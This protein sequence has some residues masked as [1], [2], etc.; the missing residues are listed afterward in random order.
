MS[1]VAVVGLAVRAPSAPTPR[2]LWARLVSGAD[3]LTR[4]GTAAETLS[5]IDRRLLSHGRHVP[6]GGVL[7]GVADIDTEFFELSPLDAALTDPQ[8]RVFLEVSREALDDAASPAA[9]DETT[10]VFAGCGMS[11]YLQHYLLSDPDLVERVGAYPLMLGNDKDFLATR[12]SYKLGLGGPSVGVQTACSTSLVAVHLAVAALLAGECDTAVAGGVTIRLPQKRGYLYQPDGV[13]SADG[14][15]RPFDSDATGFVPS[16]GAVAIVL[17]RLEDAIEDGDPI[18]AVLLATAVN[19]DGADRAGFTAPGVAGQVRVLSEALALS[20]LEPDDV[21]HV[22]THGTGTA[23]GDVVEFEALRKVYGSGTSPCYLGAGKAVIG[24]TDTAAGGLGLVK[25][26]LALQYRLI[27]PI[28]NFI[29]PNPRLDLEATRFRVAT[30]A[31]EW[32][33]AAPRR[34]AVTSLGLGGTNAHVLVEEAPQHR[35]RPRPGVVL[36]VSAH[37]VAATRARADQLQSLLR[38]DPGRAGGLARAL[39]RQRYRPVRAAVEGPGSGRISSTPAE[40]VGDP[41]RVALAFPGGGSQHAGMA[42]ALAAAE[43]DFAAAL[44]Q[45]ID[46]VEPLTGPG[47]RELLLRPSEDTAEALRRP[48]IGLPALFCVQLGL[49][50][51]LATRG[52]RPSAVIG[53]SSG[54][55]VAAC[56]AGVLAPH[57]AAEL[58]VT[59]ARMFES[60]GG[61]AMVGLLLT[62]E[63]TQPYLAV[64]PDL[65]IAAVNG[66][67]ETVVG[68]PTASVAA[69]EAHLTRLGLPSSRIRVDVAAHTTQVAHV[70]E[71]LQEA[72]ASIPLRSP[73][74]P[75]VSHVTG[76]WVGAGTVTPAY[77]AAHLRQTVRFGDA[78]RTLLEPGTLVLDVG[79]GQVLRASIER[80]GLPER[81]RVV[82]ALPHPRHDVLPA[83]QLRR[84]IVDLWAGGAEIDLSRWLPVEDVPVEPLP[85]YPFQ[86]RRCWVDPP[87]PSDARS[88]RYR[89]DRPVVEEVPDEP[90]RSEA[91]TSDEGWRAWAY[92]ADGSVFS[93]KTGSGLRH[94][95]VATIEV[96]AVEQLTSS[97]VAAPSCEGVLVVAGGDP[98][99]AYH[100]V[101][102][103]AKVLAAGTGASPAVPRLVCLVDDGAPVSGLCAAL[104]RVVRH[105]Y[106]GLVVMCLEVGRNDNDLL[107]VRRVLETG[108][109][110]AAVLRGGAR[111]QRVLRPVAVERDARPFLRRKGVWIITGGLGAIGRTLA[112]HLAV[113]A[114]ARLVF[115]ART[116]LGADPEEGAARE[117][118]LRAVTAAGGEYEVV[119][120]DI[121]DPAVARE[122]VEHADRVFG[123]VDGVIHAAGVPAGGVIE[124]RTRDETRSVLRPKVAGLL[125]LDDALGD[126]PLDALVLCSAL[127]AW[128]GTPG[129]AEHCAANGFLDAFARTRTRHDRPVVSIGWAAWR[130]IGQAAKAV[131]PE[132]LRDW[133]R[134]AMESALSPE[135]GIR[136]F[137]DALAAGYPSVVV[138][139]ED[140][141]GLRRLA[142]DAT[143]VVE[144]GPAAAAGLPDDSLRTPVERGIGRMWIELLGVATVS[145]DNDFF[146]LGGHSLAAMQLVTRLRESFGVKITLPAIIGHPVLREQVALVE[147]LLVDTVEGW[148]DAEVA[149]RLAALDAAAE[150]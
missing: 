53:H 116:R 130:G 106:P 41:A 57:E 39:S 8:H 7:D 33:A 110:D 137:G 67:S 111:L 56:V 122:A 22:E 83:G 38:G 144:D 13:L 143:R 58:V 68:G 88:A 139:A 11:S 79:P 6:V 138:S 49:W 48:G 36:P 114:A 142:A 132:A 4:F 62:E 115:V 124:L 96:P 69:L 63:E 92:L 54:E 108:A 26:I 117:A 61:G 65:E 89:L 37:S 2:E 102:S 66:P 70:G 12:V 35:A 113:A 136:V 46:V 141:S 93:T 146:A 97:L 40:V 24:H 1:A 44:A 43:P 107:G 148:D 123:G 21:T 98:E 99:W 145:A 125:A 72:A 27:P 77:W 80:A 91:T 51:F 47:I 50:T 84:A 129:Q 45:A 34:A 42:A 19:N 14:R 52:I 133:R 121:A 71:A 9:R 20:G 18:R 30:S 32:D 87:P 86:R 147:E 75:W 120:G 101:T 94:E 31:R 60:A 127:D 25:A 76:T 29:R 17:R 3:C 103:A 85:P 64:A 81:T 28:A 134:R 5:E 95:G 73:T 104:A 23:L 15:C 128:L 149:R 112:V 140:L 82:A 126:R 78:V 118:A 74:V 59:R 90:A 16:N 100:A 55:Y 150:S 10:A 131:V 105:E 109:G 119:L 135:E